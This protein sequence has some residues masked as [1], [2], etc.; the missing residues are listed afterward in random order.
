MLFNNLALL[1]L[2]P[3]M[4][5]EIE[6]DIDELKICFQKL[7][8]TTSDQSGKSSKKKSKA[9][10]TKSAEKEEALNVLFDFLIALLT[11]PQSFLRDVANFTFK[12]FCSQISPKA[13][14][15]MIEIVHTPNVDANKM[16]FD[17]EDMDDSD[18][19]DEDDGSEE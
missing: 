18:D 15:N 1:L 12:Q 7:G 4:F 16:L 10:P 3:D 17:E 8:I 5:E 19:G 2:Q 9:T 13:L 14:V 6:N 11:K